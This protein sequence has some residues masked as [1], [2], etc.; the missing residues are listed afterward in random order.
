MELCDV[1]VG[2]YV[3][4]TTITSSRVVLGSIDRYVEVRCDVRD[5]SYRVPAARDK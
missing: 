2:G 1:G 3:I 4:T 5:G